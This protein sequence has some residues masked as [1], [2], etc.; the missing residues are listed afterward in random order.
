MRTRVTLYFEAGAQRLKQTTVCKTT[1]PA[2]G[3]AVERLQR[4]AMEDGAK[5]EAFA[6]PGAWVLG[7]V[8]KGNR[9][10]AEP[11]FK[12]WALCFEPEESHG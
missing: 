6:P 12:T 3:A 9:A 7:G 1:R 2:I 11:Q 10:S 5:C 4:N 8:L